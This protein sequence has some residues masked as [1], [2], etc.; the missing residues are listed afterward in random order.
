MSPTSQPEAVAYDLVVVAADLDV[1]VFLGTMLKRGIERGCLRPHRWVIRRDPMRD[2]GVRQSPCKAIPDIRP[3]TSKILIVL[4]HHGCGSDDAPAADIE[5]AIQAQL[6]CA[7]HHRASCVVLEPEFEAVLMP[8]WDRMV[9]LLAAKRPGVAVPSRQTVLSRGGVRAESREPTETE[10]QAA[11]SNH[12]KECVL[13]LLR[14][15]RLRHQSPLFREIGQE[16]SLRALKNGAAVRRIA[17]QLVG[18]F[19]ISPAP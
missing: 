12:P 18:W 17:E 16:A 10:W 7:G 1:E 3:D 5:D 8:V 2:A 4:D 15:L 6:H 13:G 9:S 19:G 11:L 14:C